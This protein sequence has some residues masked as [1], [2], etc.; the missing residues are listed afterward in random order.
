MKWRVIKNLIKLTMTWRA[1]AMIPMA[2]GAL[3][4]NM[5]YV[6]APFSER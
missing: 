4:K 5:R 3:I 6:T 2:R 1:K